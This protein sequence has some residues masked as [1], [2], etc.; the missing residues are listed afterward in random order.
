LSHSTKEEGFSYP[1]L[2]LFE[3]AFDFY[4]WYLSYDISLSKQWALFETLSLIM[5]IAKLSFEGAALLSAQEE[6]EALKQLQELSEA[7]SGGT[8]KK[9]DLTTIIEKIIT[10]L[11]D[12]NPRAK[13]VALL[14][15]LEYKVCIHNTFDVSQEVQLLFRQELYK[16]LQAIKRTTPSFIAGTVARDL[17]QLYSEPV[18]EKTFLKKFKDSV[19]WL[20]QYSD[21]P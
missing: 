20:Y 7:I 15:R 10:K 5:Q 12:N 6:E 9:I 11:I 19:K 13:L 16:L 2:S 21:N 1:G 18:E 17:E 14:T 3:K 4:S 8:L